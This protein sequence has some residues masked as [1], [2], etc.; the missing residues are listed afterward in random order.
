MLQRWPSCRSGRVVTERA[1]TRLPVTPIIDERTLQHDL[2]ACFELE[3]GLTG[4]WYAGVLRH[5]PHRLSEQSDGLVRA[6][7]RRG[8]K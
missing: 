6:K 4:G 3:S 8:S 2:F 5:K 7:S 1:K